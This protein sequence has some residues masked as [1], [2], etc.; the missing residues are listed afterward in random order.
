MSG[1][2]QS[3]IHEAVRG[4]ISQR[5][6]YGDDWSALFDQDGIP[7]GDWNGRMINWI[8]FKLTTSY[9][10]LVEAQN[11]FASSQGFTNWGAMNTIVF[12]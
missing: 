1:P 6:G 8:N 9:T 3:G 4:Q 10:S 2:N 5:F 7:S 12:A 11:A